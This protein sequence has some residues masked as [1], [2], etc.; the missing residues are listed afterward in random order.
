MSQM[1]RPSNRN[2]VTRPFAQVKN[3]IF[4]TH[5]VWKKKSCCGYLSRMHFVQDV[6]KKCQFWISATLVSTMH[7]QL[8]YCQLLKS[9]LLNENSYIGNFRTKLPEVIISRSYHSF[10]WFTGFWLHQLTTHILLCYHYQSNQTFR[11]LFLKFD[12]SF[13]SSCCVVSNPLYSSEQVVDFC[14]FL[15]SL[16]LFVIPSSFVSFFSQLETAGT[17]ILQSR[18]RLALKSI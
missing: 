1:N 16:F 7:S 11:S 6:L 3:V 4:E 2:S 12:F 14:V 9:Q 8:L 18:L 17:Q 10:Q 13:R 5:C 15:S